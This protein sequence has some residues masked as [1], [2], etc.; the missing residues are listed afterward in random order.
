MKTEKGILIAFLLN[1]F[2]SVFE[3]IGGIVTG[4][5]AIISDAVHDIGD[6]ASIGAAFFLERKS[7]KQ[8]DEKYTYG[9]LRYSVLGGF[10]VTL[11]LV[12]GS[13]SVIGNAV[14]RLFN[15][16]EINYDGMIGFAVVGAVVNFAAAYFTHG[17]HTV[18][19][20]AVNLHMLEDVLGWAVVLVGAVIMKFTDF[21]FIDPLMSIGVAVFILVNAVKNT[22]QVLDI[23][24]EKT[25]DGI[26][27]H[28]LK[29]HLSSIEGVQNVHHIHLRSIDGN[30]NHATMHVVSDEPADEIKKKIRA[31]LKE[32]G[33][34]HATIEIE[35]SEEICGETECRTDK[36][37]GASC[38][39]GHHHHHH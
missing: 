6:A 15:P 20:K 13:V 10:I 2:F 21:S 22:K 12:I 36:T 32:H 37:E 24:L 34:S 35:T 1:L 11:I 33:I 30:V 31:E 38:C 16:T 25:P 18:N 17:G 5:V 14:R 4:S 23:F 7:K 26:S 19:S 9:Y 3:F 27:V 29:E 8:P 28:Q 39:H